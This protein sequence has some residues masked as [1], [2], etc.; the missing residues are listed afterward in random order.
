MKGL[1]IILSFFSLFV[2]AQNTIT[3]IVSE[4]N[5]KINL[6]GAS[7][8]IPELSL[9]TMS[10]KNG[11]FE[12]KNIPNGVFTID[13]S[14]LGYKNYIKKI[15]FY[16][17]DKTINIEIE[18]EVFIT[19]EIV[20]SGGRPSSQHHNAIKIESI[21]VEELDKTGEI[22]I[23]KSIS[24]VPGVDLISKGTGVATPVIRGLSTSNI[25]VLNNGVRIEDY[26]FSENHPYLIDEF[27]IS[28]IEI[29]KGPASLLYGSDAVG[30][31]INFIKEKPAKYNTTNVDLNFKYNS[32][33]NGLVSNVGLK[34]TKN[35]KFFGVRVGG[36]S[37]EDY[38]DG[39]GQIVK[40]SRNS[41]YSVKLFTGINK[42]F[43]VFRIFYDYNKM[44]LG[45]IIP[46][47]LQLVNSNS[48]KNEVWFQE[49][50]NHFLY[51]KNTLFFNK[52]KIDIDLSYQQNNRKL[53]GFDTNNYT[54][55]DMKLRSFICQIKNQY[56]FS[57]T[58]SLILGGQG[59]MQNNN[60][61]LAPSIV[62]PD[63]YTKD[64]SLFALYEQDII[65]V[66][67]FQAGL[68]Y[69]YRNIFVPRAEYTIAKQNFE[70]ID[71]TYNNLSYSIG[72]TF[73]LNKEILLRGNFASA[74][75]TP[76]VAE[77]TQNGVHGNR[78]EKGNPNLKSQISYET[79]FSGHYHSKFFVADIAMFYNKIDNYIYLSPTN[80]TTIN[81]IKIYKYQQINAKLY[82]LETGAKIMPIKWFNIIETYTNTIGIDENNNY[83]PFIPQNKINSTISFIFQPKITNVNFNIS[84]IYAFKQNKISEFESETSNYSVFNISLNVEKTLGKTVT[85]LFLTVNNIF[86][87]IYYDH[88]STLKNM[89]YYDIG[90][91][92]GVGMKVVF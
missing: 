36:K 50:D 7:I 27:G 38:T 18:P 75:R 34:S 81:G 68:R 41:Q 29:I 31:V 44:N 51:T 14:F 88:L 64:L 11:K 47:V 21:N 78:F 42:D 37:Y 80:D 43:G 23:I 58:K 35:N 2:N 6:P 30:G 92:V 12:I 66:L 90:R 48:R 73:H 89:N 83:L 45:L 52:L 54:L 53:N 85:S 55:V 63:Y 13:V 16:N 65:K 4:K 84:N 79:D 87:E 19:E 24:K 22:N 91:N 77:L 5:T 39:K 28:N 20:V 3:G 86:N 8:Y 57:K 1:F 25:L 70:Q 56:Q 33:S 76:N 82:G 69:N 40:N 72:S 17:S 74:Y 32:N 60:N 59:I 46:P 15:E 62:V 26:Q 71:N 9:G 67:H 10:D 61:N 49:L